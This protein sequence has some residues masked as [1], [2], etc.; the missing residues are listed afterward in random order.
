[1]FKNIVS[2]AL[3]WKLS[4]NR[5]LRLE[6][7]MKNNDFYLLQ[8]TWECGKVNKTSEKRN[9]QWLF[10]HS[11]FKCDQP[12]WSR[13]IIRQIFTPTNNLNEKNKL[14]EKNNDTR[15]LQCDFSRKYLLSSEEGKQF[16]VWIRNKKTNTSVS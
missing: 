6:K 5:H 3:L 13:R 8:S 4:S 16:Y 11:Y 15:R 9:R 14:N 2:L 7:H 1:M 12:T 10:R